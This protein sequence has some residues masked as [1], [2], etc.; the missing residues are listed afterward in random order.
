MLD[1]FAL[2]FAAGF[3]AGKCRSRPLKA[4]LEIG[5]ICAAEVISHF[6]ARP[7]VD[8]RELADL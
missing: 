3:L 2:L 8:L 7:E 1:R 6:G 5:A 4:C